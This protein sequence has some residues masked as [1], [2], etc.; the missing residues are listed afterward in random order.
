MPGSEIAARVAGA[1]AAIRDLSMGFEPEGGIILG[2]G[3]GAL[4]REIEGA[5]SVPYGEIPELDL[6]SVTG[7][8]LVAGRLAGKRVMA[9]E[10]LFHAYEGLPLSTVTLP[11]RILARLGARV[12]VLT[13]AAG[14]LAPDLDPGD[15]LLVDDHINLSGSNPLVGPRDDELGPLFPDLTLPYDPSL[16]GVAETVARRRS[17]RARRGVVAAV[18][19][20][21]LET[22]AERRYLRAAGADAVGMSGVAEAIVAVQCGLRVFS[23]ACL[24]D[25]CDPDSREPIDLEA[26]VEVAMM[27]EPRLTRVVVETIAGADLSGVE[28]SS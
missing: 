6:P 7:G 24:T 13:S 11:V 4:E 15:L 18:L 21:C 22:R 14:A 19:G 27:T 16:L 2:T 9:F 12:L 28:V 17:I 20:P 26:V 25:R 1:A 5:V 23:I 10:G 8:R 3:L